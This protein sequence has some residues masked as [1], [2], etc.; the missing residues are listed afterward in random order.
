MGQ[1]T[2]Y[3][4]PDTEAKIKAA[5]AAD[6]KSLSRWVGDVLRKQT[7]REWPASVLRLAG[8]WK[9]IPSPGRIRRNP[10]R[11]VAREPL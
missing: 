7:A 8:A 11:D 10:G 5:A 9:D 3:L 4:D 1:L 2:L 6:G